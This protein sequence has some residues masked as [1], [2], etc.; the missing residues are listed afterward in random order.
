MNRVKLNQGFGL[1]DFPKAKEVLINKGDC[2]LYE[3]DERANRAY[4]IVSGKLE[5]CLTSGTGHE[6]LLYHLE[7]GE[8]VGELAA[9][10]K[11]ART[12]TIAAT[13][14]TKLLEIPYA[15]L[16][17]RMQDCSFVEKVSHHFLTRYLRT[18]DVVCR[19]GQPNVSMKLCRYFKSLADQK[20]TQENPVVLK[21]PSHSE[22]GKLLSC[23]RE[24]VTREMKKLMF[25]GVVI[26]LEQT[27]LFEL[28]LKK[29]QLL[30]AGMLDAN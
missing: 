4:V 18:H 7:P 28:N 23:Q 15:D 2:L 19:L 12:A 9:F 10:G 20:D 30:L 17:S 11:K 25:R 6:T 24:T 14:A 5:V 13:M 1:K 22:M 21:L 3:G 26:P 27:G 16:V 8:L 29:N